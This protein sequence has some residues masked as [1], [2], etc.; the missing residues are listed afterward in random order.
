VEIDLTLHLSEV[1]EQAICA[2]ALVFCCW[3]IFIRK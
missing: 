2:L 1:L 3:L